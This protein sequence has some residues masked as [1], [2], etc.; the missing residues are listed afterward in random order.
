MDRYYEPINVKISLRIVDSLSLVDIH[1]MIG[2]YLFYSDI[3]TTTNK[4]RIESLVLN[5]LQDMKYNEF[6]IEVTS[7]LLSLWQENR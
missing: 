7:D 4:Y 3:I 1:Y 6:N 2:N 5:T